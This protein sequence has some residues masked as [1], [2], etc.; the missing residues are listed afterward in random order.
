MVSV[1]D[2]RYAR[3]LRRRRSFRHIATYSVMLPTLIPIDRNACP[4]PTEANRNVWS[5]SERGLA[6]INVRHVAGAVVDILRAPDL[7]P[8]NVGCRAG[9]GPCLNRFS[10]LGTK[11]PYLCRRPVF[12][13]NSAYAF[14]V[15]E[16][17]AP[18]GSTDRVDLKQSYSSHS[19][20]R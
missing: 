11:H 6:A 17:A 14:A 15:N 8:T 2:Q 13:R 10:R 3:P 18:S 19:I 1:A 16:R 9:G 7:T 20:I 12:R 4:C 5:D